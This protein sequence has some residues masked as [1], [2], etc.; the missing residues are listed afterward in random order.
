MIEIIN[1]A[2]ITSKYSLPD[3]SQHS[4]NVTTSL[5]VVVNLTESFTKTRTSGKQYICPKQEV[6]QTLTLVNLTEEEISNVKI[7]D[8]I[9][10]GASFKT[11]GIT[12]DGQSYP[13]LSAT[14]F[15]LPK[16]IE[17]DGGIVEI[18]YMIVADD[19]LSVSTITTLSNI[20]YDYVERIGLSENSN[21]VTLNVVN[22]LI[23]VKQT[24]SKTAVVAG[25]IVTYTNVVS[26]KGN[27]DNNDI[28]F[29]NALASGTEFVAGSVQ[30]D[31]AKHADYTLDGFSLDDLKAGDST[32]VSYD[33]NIK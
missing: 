6:E 22:N 13:N 21:T 10:S 2:Q 28:W 30:I 25:D 16:S 7:A 19:S 27:V 32:T 14:S 15:V 17:A 11:G 9:S 23:E 29:E 26:N 5:A 33:V 18:K 31:G 8:T 4:N 12:I 24:S 20:T 1:D 3:G